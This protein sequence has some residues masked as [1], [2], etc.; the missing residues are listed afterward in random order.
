MQRNRKSSFLHALVIV[1][2][3]ASPSGLIHGQTAASPSGLLHAQNPIPNQYIVV[4]KDNDPLPNELGPDMA[5]KARDLAGQYSGEVGFIYE[6]ALH[7]FSVRMPE[8]K[9]LALSKNPHVA[10]VEE[11]SMVLPSSTQLITGTDRWGLD[12]ID[13]RFLP[14]DS[15]YNYSYTGTG[16][17]AYILSTGIRTTQQDFG[18]RASNDVDFIGGQSGDCNGAGTFIAGLVGG[19]WFGVA[20][21]V[22]LHSVRVLD[23][24]ASAWT[25]TVIA[26]VNWVTANKVLPAVANMGMEAPGNVSLD[27]AVQNSIASGVTYVVEAGDYNIDAGLH[28]PGRVPQAITVGATSSNDVRY[29][30]SNFGPT[31]DLF[32]PGDVIFSDSNLSDFTG[33]FGESGT[34]AASAYVTGVVALY[35]QPNP[36]ASPATISAAIVAES[37]KNIV[38]DPGSGSPNALLY[39]NFPPATVTISGQEQHDCRIQNSTTECGGGIIFDTGFVSVTV[40]GR[41][42]STSYG[43]LSTSTSIAQALAASINTDPDVTAT[44]SGGAI[45]VVSRTFACYTLSVN[46]DTSQPDRFNPSFTATATTPNCS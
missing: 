16:T 23:C 39:V 31:V 9:A 5:A 7:G 27:I 26:G 38:G 40:N 43:K 10:W 46:Y 25:S 3:M 41:T 45:S 15:N 12:R 32:A 11:D 21:N 18:G 13:Q 36:S 17:N 1:S 19:A 22:K 8:A 20:K 29:G 34:F 4:L 35:L 33:T 44:S 37:T 42:Y 28:S 6:S 2:A 14:L 24:T 30:L